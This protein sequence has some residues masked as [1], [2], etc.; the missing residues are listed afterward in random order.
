[1]GMTHLAFYIGEERALADTIRHEHDFYH[2]EEGFAR[3]V[4]KEM[5][6]FIQK[7]AKQHNLVKGDMLRV[8]AFAAD[9]DHEVAFEVKLQN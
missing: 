4:Q 9:H 3:H 7:L 2:D 5:R 1:M 6:R 8:E